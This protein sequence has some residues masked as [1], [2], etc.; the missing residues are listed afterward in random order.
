MIRTRSNP[1]F[2]LLFIFFVIGAFW[3]QLRYPEN[4]HLGDIWA[5][6]AFLLMAS[7][8]VFIVVRRMKHLKQAGLK[9]GRFQASVLE[10]MMNS[11]LSRINESG[12]I[13]PMSGL[14]TGMSGI[15][16]PAF[17]SDMPRYI[18]TWNL[19]GSIGGFLMLQRYDQK[20][21]WESDRQLESI[22][23]NRNTLVYASSK[24]LPFKLLAPDFMDWYLHHQTPPVIYL[25]NHEAKIFFIP[26]FVPAEAAIPD[27]VRTVTNAIERSGAL[28]KNIKPE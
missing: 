27:I 25:R 20:P 7:V 14:P 16:L 1:T 26:P 11:F 3:W 23:F 28:E 18:I 2:F 17:S 12:Q 15:S 22:E 8:F 24:D 4:K 13:I 6:G 21:P 19:P 10:V 5:I 9:S